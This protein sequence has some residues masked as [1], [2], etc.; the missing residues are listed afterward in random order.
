MPT[1][2]CWS[3]RQPFQVTTH[4]RSR[5][6]RECQRKEEM[7]RQRERRHLAAGLATAT[8]KP[9][10]RKCQQCGQP[11]TPQRS[12]A[13]FCSASCRVAHHRGQ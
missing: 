3:C 1:R 9:I 4:S 12:T 7:T 10:K 13:R 5:R 11:F 2:I 6:C 8:G